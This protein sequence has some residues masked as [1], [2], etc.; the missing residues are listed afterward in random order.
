MLDKD[1]VL[2]G[3]RSPCIWS[4]PGLVPSEWTGCQDNGR[5]N[6]EEHCWIS[7]ETHHVNQNYEMWWML[8]GWGIIMKIGAAG[9]Q[10]WRELLPPLIQWKRSK[11]DIQGSCGNIHILIG[12]EGIRHV[13][14]QERHSVWSGKG[15]CYRCVWGIEDS[16]WRGQWTLWGLHEGGKGMTVDIKTKYLAN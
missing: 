13:I 5:E 4:E 8:P 9:L 10:M 2:V 6:S 7:H 16:F 3:A 1:H 14:R 11:R 15:I 12:P